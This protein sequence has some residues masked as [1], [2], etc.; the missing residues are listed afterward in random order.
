MKLLLLVIWTLAIAIAGF[1]AGRAS[2]RAEKG[3]ASA[4]TELLRQQARELSRDLRKAQEEVARKRDITLQIPL[5]VRSFSETLPPEA[6]PGIAVRSV[7]NFFHA[8]RVGFFAP[9]EGSGDL[10]MVEGVGFPADWK[11]KIRIPADAGMLGMAIG[12]KVVL[13]RDEYLA[14]GGGRRPGASPLE[15][16]VGAL[17]LVAPVVGDAAVGA[18]VIA[19]CP[20]NIAEERQYAS[21][22]ADLAAN[23][24]R[25]AEVIVSAEAEASVDPLTGLFNRRYLALWFEREIRQARNYSQPLSL[26][27]FDIDHFKK[28]NDTHGHAAGDLVLKRIAEIVKSSTRSSNL[29]ARFGGEEFAVVMTAADKEQA[30]RCAE[31]LREAIE[32][33]GFRVPGHPAPLNV[34]ISGGVAS[35]PADG[36]SVSEL[37]DAADAALYRAKHEGRNRVCVAW[38]LGLDGKP[39]D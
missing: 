35:F 10:T 20:G 14:A 28:V 39:I 5:V 30:R 16:A 2:R 3:Q 38:R 1:A 22:L 11:R 31:S 6:I 15:D 19:G 29:V 7:K 9:V 17:D 23:A 4:E 27:L 12:Q 18:I 37:I 34:S 21:M 25:K 33:A 32:G 26:L 36:E 13:T 24:I 8:S